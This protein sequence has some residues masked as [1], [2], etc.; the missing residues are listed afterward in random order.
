MELEL[1]AMHAANWIAMQYEVHELFEAAKRSTVHVHDMIL[2]QQQVTKVGLV[3]ERELG[4]LGQSV[5]T[6]VKP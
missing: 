5:V 2:G 6:Q 4:D 1:K 3:S